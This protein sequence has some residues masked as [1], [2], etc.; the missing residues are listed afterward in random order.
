[1]EHKSCRNCSC[2]SKLDLKNVVLFLDT[3][4]NCIFLPHCNQ[5]GTAGGCCG[6]VVETCLGSHRTLG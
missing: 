5:L 3:L 6:F 1:M 2:S 4:Q